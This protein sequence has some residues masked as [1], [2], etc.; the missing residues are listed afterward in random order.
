MSK[1]LK[2]IYTK[3]KIE[4]YEAKSKIDTLDVKLVPNTLNEYMEGISSS[5]TTLGN[6]LD[7]LGKFNGAIANVLELRPRSPVEVFLTAYDTVRQQIVNTFGDS[8]PLELRT[9]IASTFA[10]AFLTRP[11]HTQFFTALDSVKRDIIIKHNETAAADK[12]IRADDIVLFSIKDFPDGQSKNMT[13]FTERYLPLIN[14]VKAFDE[15]LGTSLQNISDIEI[16]FQVILTSVPPIT[17]RENG[18]LITYKD[19]VQS[20]NAD[21]PVF[22]NMPEGF[23]FQTVLELVFNAIKSQIDSDRYSG[24][25]RKKRKTLRQRKYFAKTAHKGIRTASNVTSSKTHRNKIKR[26]SKVKKYAHTI[27][28]AH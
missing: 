21:M 1:L 15:E 19:Y 12:V 25:L 24:G 22:S 14:Q 18:V 26:R 27:K 5:A 8:S 20:M 6:M 13:N 2:G 23:S 10:Y 16:A 4:A 17:R 28:K 3:N 7:Y 9:M 11:A